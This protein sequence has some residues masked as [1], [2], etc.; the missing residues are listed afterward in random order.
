MHLSLFVFNCPIDRGKMHPLLKKK[1][2]KNIHSGP[3]EDGNA[4]KALCF[5]V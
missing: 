5:A 1:D 4:Q 2:K 3:E